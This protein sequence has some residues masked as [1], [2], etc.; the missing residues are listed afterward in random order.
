MMDALFK[1]KVLVNKMFGAIGYKII[2]KNTFNYNIDLTD[3]EKKILDYVLKNRLTMGSKDNLAATI[4]TIRYICQN[5]IK[6][7]FVE[8]GIWRGGHGIAA[9]L[10]FDLYQS[11]NKV[12]CFDTFLGM[13]KPTDEDSRIYDSTKAITKFQSSS[14]EN[15]VEWCYASFE[16][17]E[18][19]FLR[20]GVS[21][22]NFQLIKGDVAETLP[23]F[24]VDAISFLRLDSDWYES[25]KVELKYLWP[26]LSLN[27]VLVVD[28]YGHWQG[29]KK[30]VDE[31]FQS[32]PTILFHAIDYSSRSGIKIK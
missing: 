31:F 13:T 30:A 23:K 11:K 14:R 19:N 32:S 25:T 7:H 22:A 28:D 1:S 15:H 6:G 26:L 10:T 17:V 12:I 16:E 18:N 5:K 24:E 4:L 20:A 2:A 3:Q 9:A 21:K 8:C 29:S 27:G